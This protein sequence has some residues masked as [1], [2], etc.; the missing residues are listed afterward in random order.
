MK[1]GICCGTERIKQAHDAGAEYI[2]PVMALMREKSDP[3]LREIRRIAEGTG[4][5]VDGFNCFF[6]G[7]ISL[8]RDPP[9]KIKAYIERNC[10]T[11]ALLGADYCVIGSGALRKIP[12]EADRGAYEE[13][14]AGIMHT[15]AKTAAAYG[16]TVYIEPLSRV[17]TNLINTLRDGM[18]F[19]KALCESNAGFVLDLF[20]FFVNGEELSE[21]DGLTPGQ[22]GHVHIARPDPD[23]GAPTEEDTDTLRIWSE[24]LKKARYGGRISLECTWG[25]DPAAEWNV[26]VPLVRSIFS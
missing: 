17:E 10:E 2:E 25:R 21:L 5:T 26:S 18:A 11:A 9:E 4:T 13:K 22:P 6:G 24:K 12:E 7:G 19:S 16:L 20:H 14:F 8:Y 3:E 23:R 15:V 1:I